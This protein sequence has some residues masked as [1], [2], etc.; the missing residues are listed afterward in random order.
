MKITNITS[1]NFKGTTELLHFRKESRAILDEY[2]KIECP[3]DY[4]AIA[5]EDSQSIQSRLKKLLFKDVKKVGEPYADE[6][7][8]KTLESLKN[9][10]IE[11]EE[12]QDY[13]N[14][15]MLHQGNYKDRSSELLDITF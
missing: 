1:R 14:S 15:S 3:F 2:K 12:I 9:I 5:D 10:Y 11:Q 7:D 6:N 8:K 4:I 13:Y